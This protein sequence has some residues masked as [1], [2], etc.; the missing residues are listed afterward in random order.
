MRST[1]ADLS[2]PA[3]IRAA[4]LTRFA[5]DGLSASLRTIA[6]DAG[7]S[8]GLIVHHFGSRDGLLRACHDHVLDV[9]QDQKT[10]ALTDG[11]PGT[12]IAQLAQID[13]YAPVIG[14]TLRSLQAG[15]AT[16]A[17]LTTDLRQRTQAFLEAGVEA[18]TVRPSR[19]P[20][21]RARLLTA[22]QV[23]VMLTALHSDDTHLELDELAARIREMTDS[24]LLAGLELYTQPLLTDPSLLDTVL[25]AQAERNASPPAS[26]E[27]S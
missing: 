8:A 25:N 11:T 12:M 19:D 4:A 16:A 26:E 6:A 15:G 13:E 10:L 20:E 5:T 27:T 2:A 3:R 23:G 14:F 17:Q 7:V 22:M 1:D 18:G 24:V 21:G 9:I